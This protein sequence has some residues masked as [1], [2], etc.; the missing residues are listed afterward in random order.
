MTE[1]QRLKMN[2]LKA[3]FVEA[4]TA[5]N[6]SRKTVVSYEQNVRY[7]MNWLEAETE[8]DDLAKVTTE[9]IASYQ[10]ALLAAEK[11]NG[12][13]VTVSTQHTRLTAV[14]AFLGYLW[15]EGKLL[16]NPAA[17]V[18]LPK[19]RRQLPRADLTAKEA[20]R[21]IEAA[22][23]RR[24][25]GMRDRCVVDVLYATGMRNAELRALTLADIGEKTLTVR[26]GK[27]NKDRVVPLG[28]STAACLS[29][30]LQQARPK[31]AVHDRV[32]NI[33]LTKNGMPLDTLAVINA[34]RRSARAAGITK[35]I[36]PH[37][38]RHACATHM[39][40]G[41]ADIRHIQKLLGHASL[42]TTEIYTKVEIGDLKKVH[43]LYHPRE[44]HRALAR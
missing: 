1:Q 15:R 36:H 11:R 7:F 6:W 32:H 25:L 3:R 41:G 10:T 34:V 26:S 19:L 31:L 5:W 37:S 39:L 12:E 9:T 40:K 27:G 38:L 30:Y 24:P 20:I 35:Q 18:A 4:M 14:K 21:L 13:K 17:L 43:G 44:R 42:Q 16:T 29:D 23:T 8:I 22:D 2:L 33:F 28:T